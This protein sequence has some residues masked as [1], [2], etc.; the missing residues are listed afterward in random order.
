MNIE[1]IISLMRNNPLT[2]VF[3]IAILTD[4]IFG[5]L[6]AWKQGVINSSFGI[7]G[8]IR[9][10]GMVFSI[11][12]L[13]V[14][15]Y[16]LHFNLIAY[17][18][19]GTRATLGINSIGLSTFFALLFVIYETLSIIKNMKLIGI[20]IPQFIEKILFKTL[21]TYEVKENK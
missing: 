15:D 9:K 13:F 14:V 1:Q 11:V 21:E 5:F 19:E 3:F 7:D 16:L 8:A 10:V 20:P 12:F 17:V 18:D 4:V 2:A 6:R